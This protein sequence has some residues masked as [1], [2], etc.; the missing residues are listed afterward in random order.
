VVVSAPDAVQPP[1]VVPVPDA[2]QPPAVVPVP[3]AVQ[4]PAATDTTDASDPAANPPAQLVAS[5]DP[6]ASPAYSGPSS[7]GSG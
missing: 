7:S 4:P 3:D 5:I 2:V 6:S 1:A